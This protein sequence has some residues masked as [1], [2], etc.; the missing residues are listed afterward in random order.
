MAKLAGLA[1][2]IMIMVGSCLAQPYALFGFIF[3]PEGEIPPIDCLYFIAETPSGGSVGF[4]G[5]G[6]NYDTTGAW[7]VSVGAFDPSP[8]HGD[9]IDFTFVNTCT[10][11]TVYYSIIID[12]TQTAQGGD[13]V[14]F[15]APMVVPDPKE[16][17][18]KTSEITVYPNPFNAT[19]KITTDGSV[20][21]VEVFNMAGT[22]VRTLT[23]NDKNITWDGHDNTGKHLSSGTYFL[24]TM[25]GHGNVIRVVMLR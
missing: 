3:G 24:R 13:T 7:L 18:L 6:T 14:R 8:N 16:G 4:P 20:G 2:I 9:E 25:G 10:D 15:S 5:T 17:Q 1:I 11:D 19:C 23:T 12:T 21:T 22:L